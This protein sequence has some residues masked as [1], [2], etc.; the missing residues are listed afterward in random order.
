M[1][2]GPAR[3]LAELLSLPRW[4]PKAILQTVALILVGTIVF[5]PQTASNAFEIYVAHQTERLTKI[6]GDLI[7]TQAAGIQGR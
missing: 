6:M 2:D 1:D 4:L 5:A 3:V 7:D